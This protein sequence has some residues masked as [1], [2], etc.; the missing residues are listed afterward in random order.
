MTKV[1][2]KK[3]KLGHNLKYDKSQFM[4]TK[5]TLKWSFSRN[6]STS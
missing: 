1:I 2:K 6:I 5:K 3:L 4:K